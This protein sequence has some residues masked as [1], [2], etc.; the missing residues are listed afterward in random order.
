[1]TTTIHCDSCGT[2]VPKGEYAYLNISRN[3]DEDVLK[4]LCPMCVNLLV[5]W[6]ENKDTYMLRKTGSEAN[7][8]NQ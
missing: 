4:D 2:E 3:Y 8:E 7:A 6:I 1:M 5:D